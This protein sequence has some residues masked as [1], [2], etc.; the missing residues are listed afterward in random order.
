MCEVITKGVNLS[1]MKNQPDKTG[2]AHDRR[3][4]RPK[5][6]IDGGRLIEG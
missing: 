1:N 6:R 2:P 3:E 4:N 5:V